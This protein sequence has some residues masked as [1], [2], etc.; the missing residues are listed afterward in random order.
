MV[1]VKEPRSGSEL[2]RRQRYARLGWDGWIRT[3]KDAGSKPA[4]LPVSLHPK[5]GAGRKAGA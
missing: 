4:G 2:T 5:C 1:D 3:T